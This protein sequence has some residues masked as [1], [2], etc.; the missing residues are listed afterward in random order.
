MLSLNSLIKP[1][2]SGNCMIF[3]DNTPIITLEDLRDVKNLNDSS[4][5]RSEKIE[6]LNNISEKGCWD[7]DEIFIE[8]NY[9]DSSVFDCIVYYLAGYM[10]KRMTVKTKCQLCASSIKTLNTAEYDT[11]A[12]LIIAKSRGYLTHP[13]SIIY[14]IIKTLELSISQ[15]I[16][17]PNAFEE[18]CE[19]FLKQ[20]IIF[21]FP[22]AAHKQNV[23]TD[24]CTHY[25]IMRM[26]QYTFI[27]NQ[28]NKKLNKTKKKLAKLVNT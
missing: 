6:K 10:A 16:N 4:S 8:H 26:R 12:D 11:N 20:K 28:K 27:N 7:V 23:L 3:E 15:F 13:N 22:C 17:S 1:P 5:V 25:I 18:I 19:D 24:I 9:S 21:D 14:K 2:K